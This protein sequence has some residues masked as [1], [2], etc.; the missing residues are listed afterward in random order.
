[1]DAL[2]AAVFLVIDLARIEA[3]AGDFYYRQLQGRLTPQ[4]NWWRELLFFVIHIAG[5]IT[6]SIIAGIRI[7]SSMAAAVRGATLG[8]V[9]TGTFDET[10]LIW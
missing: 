7:N 5:L 10:D 4:V 9:A 1:L 3:V 6:V 2:G 8:A